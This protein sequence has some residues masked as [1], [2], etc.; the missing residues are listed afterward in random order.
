M[1][2]RLERVRELLKRELS[3]IVAREFDFAAALVTIQA[4]DVTPDLKKAHVDVSVVGEEPERAGVV[5][6]LNE[7]RVMLQHAL[8]RRV[9][10]KFTPQLHF[11]LDESIERGVRI[12]QMID[13]IV[14]P[15]AESD[16]N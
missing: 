10:L 13:E 12:N 8:S 15:E 7:S 6:K 3:E 2:H 5:A 4:V 16:E 14:V 11:R 1:K 9:T